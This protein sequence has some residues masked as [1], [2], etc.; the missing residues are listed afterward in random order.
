MQFSEKQLRIILQHV[1]YKCSCDGITVLQNALKRYC[2]KAVDNAITIICLSMFGDRSLPK[3][4]G[5]GFFATLGTALKVDGTDG[6]TWKSFASSAL[7]RGV[8]HDQRNTH[9]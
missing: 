3:A 2:D 7:S 1:C 8:L 9:V 5:H 6:S 4:Q